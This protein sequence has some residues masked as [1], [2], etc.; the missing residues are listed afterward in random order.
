MIKPVL[1]TLVASC[2]TTATLAQGQAA[3][4]P[5]PPKPVCESA[6]GFS[7]FDFWLGEWDVY[8]NDDTR[9]F[10]GSNSIT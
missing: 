4:S 8:T 10:Q 6:T 2:F 9:Q 1:T 5:A 7:D 3:E